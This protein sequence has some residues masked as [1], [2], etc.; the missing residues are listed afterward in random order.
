MNPSEY[1]DSTK[2]NNREA[3]GAFVKAR[4]QELDMSVRD[5]AKEVN[6]TPAYISDIEKGNR[7][8]PLNHLPVFQKALQIPEDQS[9][10]FIDLAG[11]YSGN[12]PDLN[13]YLC[14]TPNARK[15]FRIAKRKN[16]S[17]EEILEIVET[18]SQQKE[19]NSQAADEDGMH[20]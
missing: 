12:W 16:M 17:G 5:L 19:Q 1:A 4:R 14:K 7:N 20:M 9:D 10:A 13:E 18:Y 11:V 15:F 8:A 2:Y 3:F 6:L